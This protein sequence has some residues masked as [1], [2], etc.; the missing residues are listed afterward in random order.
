MRSSQS[1]PALVS[2]LLLASA[3][4]FAQGIPAPDPA[5]PAKAT[6]SPVVSGGQEART[7]RILLED[8]AARIDELRIGGET[9][10]ITVT[11]K[12]GMPAYD[13]APKTGERTWKILDF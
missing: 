3:Q 8:D 2:A 11:P 6:P 5:V 13:V 12:D 10:T 1:T 9:R 4:V 7:E